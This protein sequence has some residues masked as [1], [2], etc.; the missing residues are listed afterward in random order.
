MK[1]FFFHLVLNIFFPPES[2]KWS[3]VFVFVFFFW[4]N[5]FSLSLTWFFFGIILFFL[6]KTHEMCALLN[7][8]FT[9]IHIF[10]FLQEKIKLSLTH[11][12]KFS[13]NIFFPDF[14]FISF[15]FSVSR[16]FFSH[17]IYFLTCLKFLQFLQFIYFS[18]DNFFFFIFL[19]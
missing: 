16:V 14:S 8:I 15:H 6:L 1:V 12:K 13:P 5:C 3:V 19:M 7:F 2:N 17:K 4:K 18:F 11:E 9:R 10:P